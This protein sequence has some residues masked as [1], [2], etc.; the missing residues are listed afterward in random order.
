[1]PFDID[2]DGLAGLRPTVARAVCRVT[3][4][5]V[6]RVTTT[7]TS[8]V[9]GTVFDMSFMKFMGFG[10]KTKNAR[11]FREVLYYGL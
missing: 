8:L 11:G 9:A 2:G 5:A 10:I 4:T 3:T 6:C 7:T 1:M